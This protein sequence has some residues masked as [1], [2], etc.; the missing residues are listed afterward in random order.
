M[1]HTQKAVQKTVLEAVHRHP[2]AMSALFLGHL[3]RGNVLGRIAEKGLIDS[4]SFGALRSVSPLEV[5]AAI[6]ACQA[7]GWV[8]K[9]AGPYAALVLTHGGTAKVNGAHRAELAAEA[10]AVTLLSSNESF[11]VYHDWR[12]KLAARNNK[13]AYRVLTNTI[14]NEL[15]RIRP[16]TLGEL[17]LVP[18][19]GKVRAMRYSDELIA[20]GRQLRNQPPAA[21]AV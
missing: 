2:G 12:R 9:V 8:T 1:N 7:A 10:D 14:L 6:A 18:G 13:P 11:K 3:L 21:S 17:L 19:L 15:A 20:I 4:P 5:D 16:A